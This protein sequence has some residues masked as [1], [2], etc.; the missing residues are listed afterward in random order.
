MFSPTEKQ[1]KKKKKLC[2][3][4]K[5]KQGREMTTGLYS[6]RNSSCDKLY[7]TA[8]KCYLDTWSL[9]VIS[10]ESSTAQG[11]WTFKIMNNTSVSHGLQY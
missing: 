10:V 2:N 3:L 7:H 9:C 1:E 11:Y 8:V 4:I 5:V 6:A